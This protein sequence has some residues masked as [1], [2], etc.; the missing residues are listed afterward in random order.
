MITAIDLFSG[1]GGLTLGLK[2]A[3]FTVL[4]AVEI[5]DLFEYLADVRIGETAD[6]VLACHQ[7]AE[8]L[9]AAVGSVRFIPYISVSFHQEK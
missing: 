3:G 6:Q 9:C 1:C 2:N 4:A 8:D 5:D 7:G